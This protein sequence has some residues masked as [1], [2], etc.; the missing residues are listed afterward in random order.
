VL[1]TQL[2]PRSYEEDKWGNQISS[3]RESVKK[4]SVGRESPS[5]ED[6]SSEAEESPLLEAVTRERLVKTQQAGKDLACAVVILKVWR[7]A[8]EL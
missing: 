7:S 1:S 2:V 4:K 6:L 8:M 3:V 5:R